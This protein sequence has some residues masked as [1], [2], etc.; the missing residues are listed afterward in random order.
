VVHHLNSNYLC[1][2]IYAV[3]FLKDVLAQIA[4]YRFKSQLYQRALAILEQTLGTDH[5]DTQRAREDYADLLLMMQQ[6]D[7]E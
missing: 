4:I 5:P 2:G 3:C 1:E 6:A 7:Q